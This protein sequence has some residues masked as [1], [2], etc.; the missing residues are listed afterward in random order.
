MQEND[1]NILIQFC[2]SL[3]GARLS[4]SRVNVLR[5][6]GALRLLS[7]NKIAGILIIFNYF[8]QIIQ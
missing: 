4:A 5:V 8:L 3:P 6:A 2:S 1:N 7:G